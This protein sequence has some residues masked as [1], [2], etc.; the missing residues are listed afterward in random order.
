MVHQAIEPIGQARPDWQII[1]GL[2]QHLP[3]NAKPGPYAAWQY[4]SSAQI[5]EEI[6][7]LAPIYAG[8]SHARLAGGM[9]LQWP[10]DSTDHPGTPLLPAGLFSSSELRWTPVEQIPL[11]QLAERPPELLPK[12]CQFETGGPFCRSILQL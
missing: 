7:A 11:D 2:A 6:A 12:G 5:M 4:A 1:A 10:V 8:V 3:P 9:R